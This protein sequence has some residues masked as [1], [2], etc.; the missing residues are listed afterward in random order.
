MSNGRFLRTLGKQQSKVG[1]LTYAPDERRLLSTISGG[2][3]GEPQIVWDITSGN[4]LQEPRHHDNV[5]LAAAISPNGKLAAT[6]GGS[7]QEIH[8]LKLET[9]AAVNGPQGGPLVLGGTGTP[10]W[11]VGFSADGRRI[12]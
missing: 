1:T 5:V 4:R 3:P 12:T 8:I 2:C 11:A 9:G 6:G 10:G 7:R